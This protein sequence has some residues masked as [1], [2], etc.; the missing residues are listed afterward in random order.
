MVH[1]SVTH[2][3]SIRTL[4]FANTPPLLECLVPATNGYLA[5]WLCVQN[6]CCIIVTGS[7]LATCSTHKLIFCGAFSG[8]STQQWSLGSF[9]TKFRVSC[10]D[11]DRYEVLVCCIYFLYHFQSR[12]F[13]C[14]HP[15]YSINLDMRMVAYVEMD[16]T[17]S[18]VYFME[19]HQH[20]PEGLIRV[21]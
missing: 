20:V 10:T 11:Q 8:S 15:V 21:M 19:K 18:L 3:R 5:G 14:A 17:V 16:T 6:A 9:E 2:T 12:N 4:S 1:I 7:F 13:L